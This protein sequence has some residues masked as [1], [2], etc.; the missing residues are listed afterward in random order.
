MQIHVHTL[1]Q[2]KLSYTQEGDNVTYNVAE[3]SR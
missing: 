1:K 2:H 3:L